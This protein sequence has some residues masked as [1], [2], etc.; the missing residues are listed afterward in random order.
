MV[1]ETTLKR[2]IGYY[3]SV[4]V[5]IDH[6]KSIPGKYGGF[7]QKIQIP[8][9]PKFCT[10]CKVVG[11]YVDGCRVKRNENVQK[12]GE[13]KIRSTV[14]NRYRRKNE[15]KEDSKMSIGFDIYVNLKR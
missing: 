3:A 11:D 14:A 7:S 13:M 9:L 15:N 5:E 2:K 8:K 12:E 4:L 1:D 10:R 6:N